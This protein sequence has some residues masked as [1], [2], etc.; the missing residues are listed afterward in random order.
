MKIQS[1]FLLA[2][3]GMFA[4][5]DTRAASV[6][7]TGT[8]RD[9]KAFGTPGGHADFEHFLGFDPG[10]VKT[11]LGLDGK[12]VYTG[13]VGNPTTTGATEFDQWYR[14]TAGVNL[15]TPHSITLTELVPGSGEFVFDSPSFFPIDGM[16]FNTG[17]PGPNYHFT[18]ELHTTFT[19][20]P[21]QTFEFRSDDE[22]WVFIDK[23]LAIDLG[24]VHGAMTGSVALDTLSLTAG[25]TY[26]L[27]LFFAERHTV[28]S[29]FKVTTSIPLVT[30]PVPDAFPSVYGAMVLGLAALAPGLHRRI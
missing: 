24:G 16:L 17:I 9:F 23:K 20:V 25:S 19:Y 3:L 29:S 13:T 8:V 10:I 21:G 28:A 2:L 4:A 6:T 26:S 11:D 27:D 1:L 12:P 14:D 18:F 7:L 22:L 30:V 5:L 15:S